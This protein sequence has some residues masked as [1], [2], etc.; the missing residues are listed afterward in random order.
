MTLL[1]EMAAEKVKTFELQ[2]FGNNTGQK[3]IPIDAK[4]L[5]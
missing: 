4:L 5:H 1:Y 3:E 2:V